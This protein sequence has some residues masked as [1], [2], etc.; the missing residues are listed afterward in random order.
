MVGD[1]LEVTLFCEM[2]AVFMSFFLGEVDADCKS[3]LF[4][5]VDAD[6]K[7]SPFRGPG[8][9]LPGAGVGVGLM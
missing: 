3:S 6:C 1:V 9:R 7:L 5:R 2:D 8:A 4:W